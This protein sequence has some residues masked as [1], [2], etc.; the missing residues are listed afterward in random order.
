MK[1]VEVAIVEYVSEDQP[2]WVR[3]HLIDASNRTWTFLE[4][5]P[6]VSSSHLVPTSQFPQPGLVACKLL[7]VFA[8]P[9]GEQIARIDTMEPWGVESEQGTSVFEV[10]A[11]L[12]RD[13]PRVA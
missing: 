2:G 9:R 3:C 6:V 7:S 1:A 11:N 12:L 4:K 13:V 8:S 10:S 5:T